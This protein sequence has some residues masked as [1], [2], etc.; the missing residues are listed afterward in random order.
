MSK[1]VFLFLVFCVG[2]LDQSQAQVRGNRIKYKAEKLTNDTRDGV[3]FKKLLDKV[4]FKQN[5]TTVYCDSA[6]FFKEENKMEAFGRVRIKDGDS[7]TIRSKTLIYEGN[8]GL[9]QLRDEVVYRRGDLSLYTDF[10][11]YNL[12]LEV[13]KFFNNGKLVDTENTLTSESGKFLSRSNYAYF[14]NDVLLVAPEYNL[15]SDTLEYNTVTQVAYTRGPT[16]IVNRDGST[17]DSDGGTFRT[18][19]EQT[20][21]EAGTIE[22][23]NYKIYGDDIF[24]DDQNR[25]YR[26]TGNVVMT[27]KKDNIIIFGKESIYDKQLGIS[28][29]YGDPLMKRVMRE[30]TLFMSA[31][32]LVAIE[33]ADKDKERVLAYHN[34][35]M[36][37][38]TLQ[39]KCDS[40]AY[41]LADST[42]HMFQ[43]P[44]LWNDD[45]Q[46]E[47]D[48]ISILFKYEIINEL[49]LKRNSFMTS[50]DT[51]GQH[52]QIKGRKMYGYFDQLGNLDVM[53]IDGNGESHY[54]VL[55]GDSLFVGMNKIFCSRMRMRFSD[56][57]LQNISFYTNPDAQFIPPHELKK[58]LVF[59]EGFNWRAQERPEKSDVATYYQNLTLPDITNEKNT[60]ESM[61]ESLEHMKELI[62]NT[63]TEGQPQELLDH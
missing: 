8:T 57:D 56:N 50:L 7:V 33:H 18:K 23:K 15:K 49:R 16:N 52:N 3:K 32:T 1:K 62:E 37:K 27:S 12:I 45:S 2:L 11:D 55:E 59:L 34:I 29:V 63:K 5:Q 6:Y 41:F 39:G 14:Y 25:F 42:M 44:V 43:D 21:F 31:D 20:V 61:R 24:I 53:D 58:E 19:I 38:E 22:T 46:M 35:L 9:A 26:A 4:V 10:L 54:F 28:K 51:M 48:T 40:V 60:E 17:V 13:A 47:A 36:Y 30:D